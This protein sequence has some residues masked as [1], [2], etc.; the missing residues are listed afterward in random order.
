[1][2]K[3]LLKFQN[4]KSKV[5]TEAGILKALFVLAF[6]EIPQNFE[7]WYQELE[8]NNVNGLINNVKIT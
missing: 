5:L 7:Y 4:E 2:L 6:I 8:I 1:L 3:N